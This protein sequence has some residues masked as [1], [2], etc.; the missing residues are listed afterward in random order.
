M[1]VARG[2]AVT[3]VDSSPLAIR[4]L[5]A[6]KMNDVDAR[7]GDIVQFSRAI[8]PESFA[9]I[10]CNHG[11][12]YLRDDSVLEELLGRW[13]A[14]LTSGGTLALAYFTEPRSLHPKNVQ[15]G[16]LLVEKEALLRR[17]LDTIG[18]EVV[19]FQS[20]VMQELHDGEFHQHAVERLIVRKL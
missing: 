2:Y 11:I 18:F 14:A 13:E 17:Y 1:L 16:A 8:E 5:N 3:A 9:V 12:Q 15:E 4:T 20:E 19:F 6:L 7:V 10:L